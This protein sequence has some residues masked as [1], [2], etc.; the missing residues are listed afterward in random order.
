L[1]SINRELNSSNRKWQF[2]R[3]ALVIVCFLLPFQSQA[4]NSKNDSLLKVIFVARD[5]QL[6]N[7]LNLLAYNYLKDSVA[8]SLVTSRQALEIAEKLNYKLG[9]A[10][11]N[12]NIAT[13]L[14]TMAIFEKAMKHAIL[15]LDGFLEIKD[16]LNAALSYSCIGGIYG[17]IKN[18]PL[19]LESYMKMEQ[20]YRAVG[21]QKGILTA[22]HNQSTAYTALDQTAKAIAIYFENLRALDTIN[23]LKFRA[24]TLNN[25]GNI[26]RDS[27]KYEKAIP[28]YLESYAI[29][30]KRKDKYGLANTCNNLG[31]TYAEMG[32]FDLAQ[33]YLDEGLEYCKATKAAD[34]E[35]E[36]LGLRSL[37][38][39][40]M[41]KFSESIEWLK[42]ANAI[43]DT[44]Y[45]KTMN[46]SIADLEAAYDNQK[47][48]DQID[49]LNREKS[50][51]DDRD[52]IENYFIIAL[53]VGLILVAALFVI[54]VLNFRKIKSQQQE[55]LV[56]NEELLKKN[57]MLN[58][59]NAEKDGLISIVAHD[60]RAPLNRS[61]ALSGLISATG[62]MNAEQEKYASMIIRIAEDGNQ[63]IEDL[64]QLSTYEQATLKTELKPLKMN[65]F[66]EGMLKAYQPLVL[67]KN[68]RFD[69]YQLPAEQEIITDYRLLGRIVDN[70]LSNAIKF[71]D[72]GKS[73]NVSL[74]ETSGKITLAVKDQGP[75]MPAEEQKKLFRKFTRLSAKPTGGESSTGLGLAIV[76]IL[77]DKLHATIE[78][79]STP[80]V[81]SEFRII[82]PLKVV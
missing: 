82:L 58:D 5:T 57:E 81:G 26:Y 20:C 27:T 2:L 55:I 8:Q 14:T 63:L 32:K 49:F 74:T 41:G 62:P 40:K 69:F 23:D 11:S 44:L 30:L 60:L 3:K 31:E 53:S 68:Q 67:A 71:S 43:S 66:I 13:A 16:T 72:K 77:A 36:N 61:S 39:E 29:K 24:A 50:A 1:F 4:Q 56:A 7:S 35:L 25:I 18:Y 9:V 45:T 28:Y 47:K 12:L 78:V 70:L 64:L 6:V 75:G 46:S 54:G 52:R 65:E 79:D 33:K 51:M 38:A 73:I 48:Q 21:N 22:R 19:A 80:G 10:R 15:S 17:Q 76:K 59:I 34:R 42:K 37:L